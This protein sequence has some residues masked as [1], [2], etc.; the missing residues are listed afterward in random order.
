LSKYFSLKAAS[1][2]SI[3]PF[4]CIGVEDAAAG[5]TAIKAAGMF[6]VGIGEKDILKDADIVYTYTRDIDLEQLL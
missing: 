4:G 1:A 3:P 6:A 5:I 2:L